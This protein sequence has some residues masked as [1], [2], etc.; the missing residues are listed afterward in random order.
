MPWSVE[1][2]GHPGRS[3]SRRRPQ[4][5]RLDAH[6]RCRVQWYACVYVGRPGSVSGVP[7]ERRVVGR[8]WSPLRQ[9]RRSRPRRR[10]VPSSGPWPPGRGAAPGRHVLAQGVH[11]GHP[12]LS[13]PVSLPHLRD[14]AGVQGRSRRAQLMLRAGADDLGGT[15]MEGASCGHRASG[16]PARP[17]A[18]DHVPTGRSLGLCRDQDQDQDHLIVSTVRGTA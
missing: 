9:V 11:P 7:G 12:A 14:G 18:D 6:A 15:V 2:P 3:P 5:A 1:H 16:P 8:E 10:R 17:P 13:R 4:P